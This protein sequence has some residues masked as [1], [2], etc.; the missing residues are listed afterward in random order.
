MLICSCM[1]RQDRGSC[2]ICNYICSNHYRENLCVIITQLV[3]LKFPCPRPF[4]QLREISVMVASFLIG[5]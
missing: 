1:G 5:Q 3:N 2:S 4:V